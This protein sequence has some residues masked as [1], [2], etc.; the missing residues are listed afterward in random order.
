MAVLG[1]NEQQITYFDTNKG[2]LNKEGGRLKVF[3]HLRFTCI[4]P[5]DVVVKERLNKPKQTKKKNRKT[6]VRD[7]AV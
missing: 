3:K 7:I 6:L 4:T 2:A 5:W 1:E